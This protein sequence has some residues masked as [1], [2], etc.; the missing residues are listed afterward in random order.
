MNKSNRYQYGYENELKLFHFF[1]EKF[2]SPTLQLT[3]RYVKV[4]FI[5]N[6]TKI[7]IELK[8]RDIK[9]NQ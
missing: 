8:S 3:D 5:D 1:K 7:A 4:D 6:E 9:A 2:N